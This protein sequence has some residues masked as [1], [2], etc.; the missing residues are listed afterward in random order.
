MRIFALILAACAAST[1][2]WSDARSAAPTAFAQQLPHISIETVGK[3]DP[4]VLI[5]GLASPRT[6][7]GPLVPRLAKGHRVILVQVNGF[8]GSEPGANLQPG[9]LDGIVADL[10]AYLT[11]HK[12]GAAPVI[13]HSMGGLAGL[14]F[15]LAHPQRV[16]RLM[17]VDALPFFGALM[18]EQATPDIV[19]P[20]AQMM[21]R[22]V[23]ASFGEP[24]DRAA[25]EA[26][27]KGL[28]L[29]PENVAT[30]ADWS[31]AADPRVTGELLYED[32]T[33]DVRPQ[34]DALAVPTT[35]L[36][37]FETAA[38]EAKVL[39]FY[40]RQYAKVPAITFTGVSESAHMV[41]LDQPARFAEKVEAFLR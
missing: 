3:G 21:Q 14:K 13:G 25:A 30:M 32:M 20:I 38:G 15:A 29:K 19:R 2:S 22:K 40:K 33:T 10:D 17:I 9:A 8:G 31:L 16:K 37:P 26:N 12:I 7:W 6:V 1:L 18:D 41:M 23:A 34:L 27:V 39:A 28:S 24:A 36:Y 35:L 11:S 4:V 5:P